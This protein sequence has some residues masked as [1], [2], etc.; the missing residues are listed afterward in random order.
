MELIENSVREKNLSGN[1]NLGELVKKFYITR[2]FSSDKDFFPEIN[3]NFRQEFRQRRANAKKTLTSLA[4]NPFLPCEEKQ[5]ELAIEE[6]IGEYFRATFGSYYDRISND[7]FDLKRREEFVI[8]P[9]GERKVK[10][11]LPLFAYSSTKYPSEG[12]WTHKF[13]VKTTYREYGSEREKIYDLKVDS[14]VPPLSNKARKEALL[15]R[16]RYMK[17]CSEAY[18]EPVLGAIF[19]EIAGRARVDRGKGMDLDLDIYWIPSSADLKLT[20]VKTNVVDRDP[21]LI[22]TIWE[23]SYLI[24]KWDVRGEI[25]YEHYLAEFTEQKAERK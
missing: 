15:A 1:E 8:D 19:A 24:H 7:L 4:L 11:N 6:S 16:S 5:K 17:I 23:D 12:F 3:K 20:V 14:P 21:L 13:E 22:G 10:V 9:K 25:P 2:R 18:A